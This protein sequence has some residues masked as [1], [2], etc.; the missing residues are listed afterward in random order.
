VGLLLLGL[1]A[2]AL[3][4]WDLVQTPQS[5]QRLL[6]LF[7]Y[8]YINN[9]RGRAWPEQMN[10]GPWLIGFATLAGVATTVV[11]LPPLRRWGALAL[12]AVAVIFTY[13]TL[14][15]FLIE[16]SPHWSQKHLLA[17]YYQMRQPG[18]KLI[19]WQM[20]W[21]GETFYTSNE[22]FDHRL[23][24]DEKTVF[25][26]ERNAENMQDWLRRHTGQRV[27][28]IIEHG[29]LQTL[30][31]LMPTQSAKDTLRVVDETSNKFLLAM[32]QN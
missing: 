14:D 26:G 5:A 29:R 6:W 3:V 27:F 19:A 11:A 1:P 7:D 30:K 2:L 21:R 12:C 13:F 22:I 16:L 32:A 9:P 8:D 18:E 23:Q 17:T 4:T 20:Y 10:Y 25:L 28:F 15:K 31:T 24:S